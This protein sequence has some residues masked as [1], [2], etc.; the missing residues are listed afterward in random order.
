[1]A[2]TALSQSQPVSRAV[3]VISTT[4]PATTRAAFSLTTAG[5]PKALRTDAITRDYGAAFPA[6]PP[7]STP[8]TRLGRARSNQDAV[9][10]A[11]PPQP[12]RRRRR[13]SRDRAG[14]SARAPVLDPEQLTGAVGAQRRPLHQRRQL[15]GPAH[16]LVVVLH[17]LPPGEHHV[18]F[19]PHP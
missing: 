19:H 11:G 13:P 9:A 8:R 7:A 3:A 6:C 1:M 18:V 16:Q 15:G 14:A 5:N 4:P 17:D 2:S 12:A 10:P